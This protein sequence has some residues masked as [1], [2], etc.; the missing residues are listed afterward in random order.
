MNYKLP[1][2]TL[3]PLIPSWSAEAA[4][5][6]R[7]LAALSSDVIT[8]VEPIRVARVTRLERE[9]PWRLANIRRRLTVAYWAQSLPAGYLVTQG[10]VR[11]PLAKRH[12]TVK[13]AWLGVG[14]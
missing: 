14:P 6:R 7:Q 3:C 8:S 4:H 2:P 12:G 9:A 13:P 5:I 10:L 11:T 1:R